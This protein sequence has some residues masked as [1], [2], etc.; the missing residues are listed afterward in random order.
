MKPVFLPTHTNQ[1]VQKNLLI[2]AVDWPFYVIAVN[3]LPDVLSRKYHALV[4]CS[5]VMAIIGI[6]IIFYTKRGNIHR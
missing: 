6:L 4:T 5:K 2:S 1:S 3:N